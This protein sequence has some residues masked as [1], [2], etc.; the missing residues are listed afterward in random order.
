M[1]STPTFPTLKPYILDVLNAAEPEDFVVFD[2]DDTVLSG[3]GDTVTPVH[4]GLE[5]V[6]AA[7]DRG[8][9]V[10]YVTARP[11]FPRNRRQTYEDLESVGIVNPAMVVMRPRSVTSWYG[12]GKFKQQARDMIQKLHGGKCVLTAG[13]RFTDIFPMT[14]EEMD[15]MNSVLGRNMYSLF[16]LLGSDEWGL[17]LIEFD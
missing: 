10:Y 16:K 15:Q 14:V 11:E 12:I 4:S 8:L 9:G 5:L 6:Q 13:D 17:K 7:H 1:W 2:I 3:M